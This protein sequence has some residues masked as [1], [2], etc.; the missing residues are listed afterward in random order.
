MFKTIFQ[1]DE[2][3]LDETCNIILTEVIVWESANS[4]IWM[5]D[6][7]ILGNGLKQKT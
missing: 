6:K 3:N 1:S 5:N 4:S 7:I 2:V